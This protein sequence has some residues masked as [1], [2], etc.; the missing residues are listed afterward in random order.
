MKVWI[1]EIGEPL[2]L[3]PDVRLHRH[4]LFSKFLASQNVDVTWW[5]S[6]FSHAPKK[7]FVEHD[8]LRV[9]DGVK[10]QFIRGPGYPRNISLA[11]I[12]H[13]KHFASRF[14]ELAEQSEQPDVIIAPI[15]IIEAAYE[16]V[17]YA[18][19]RG[20]KV[21]A[22]IRDLWP[23][24]LKERAPKPLQPLARLMLFQAYRKM[25][26][27]CK[28]ADGIM[29]I[30]DSYLQYGLDFAQ[31]SR[32]PTDA[33]F[34]L[35]YSPQSVSSDKLSDARAWRDQQGLCTGALNICFFGTIGKYFDLATVIQA[36]RE[37]QGQANIQWILCG[38]GSEAERFKKLAGDLPHVKFPGWVK[39]PQ[40]Q[41]L[42][43]KAH[44]GLAPYRKDA[45]MALPNKPFEYMSGGLA[46]LSSIK[47]EL[48]DLL[49][50]H[51]CGVSYTAD[52]VSDLKDKVLR[53]YKD[54]DA[55][56]AM[57]DRGRKLFLKDFTTE[58]VFAKALNH[59]Q[60][61]AELK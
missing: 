20:V 31:R 19:S 7:H 1:L 54:Q 32:A 46:V 27:F 51:K 15:P 9:V 61:V 38:D 24:E 58:Q 44:V 22:D 57:G 42:M 25:S 35:G 26:H 52:S 37:V 12:R 13:N 40:I 34:H 60:A 8:E 30:C 10:M 28:N 3:E 23:Q 48:P 11:R 17:E 16:A 18:K 5:T 55:C 29:G 2:P 59:I 41:A 43:E 21:L 39:A 36:A 6:S 47:Q 4:G 50:A 56:R 53:L 49:D 33:V 45:H 14:R